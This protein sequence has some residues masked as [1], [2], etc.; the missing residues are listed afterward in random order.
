MSYFTARTHPLT[1]PSS[2]AVPGRLN[3]RLQKTSL[4][5]C[6]KTFMQMQAETKENCNFQITRLMLRTDIYNESH[7]VGLCSAHLHKFCNTN[8]SQCET[9]VTAA[10]S[11]QPAVNH[12]NSHVVL[13]HWQTLFGEGF[14]GVVH[15]GDPSQR[16]FWT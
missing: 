10:I 14:G 4:H 9:T 13:E 15:W 7:H 8:Q 5:V 16:L 6:S 11:G 2:V 1:A 12:T 3:W